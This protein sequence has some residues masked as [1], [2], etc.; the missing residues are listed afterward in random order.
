MPMNDWKP[1]RVNRYHHF[2]QQW[3][4]RL[5]DALN[6][7]VLPKGYFALV[8]QKEPPYEPDVMALERNGQPYDWREK[9][10]GVAVAEIPPR[11]RVV[12]QQD[13]A[14]MYAKAA[15]RLGVRNSDGELV[16]IIEIVSPGK[17][18][19]KQSMEDFVK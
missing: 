8:E 1:V 9:A 14:D 10:G 11:A 16:A 17:K 4:C 19:S 2:H 18:H 6:E 15:N 13:D 3:S 12:S 7:G 5:C